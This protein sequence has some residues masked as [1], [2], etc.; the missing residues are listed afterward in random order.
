[1]E[2]N[3]IL[4][5]FLYE[6]EVRNYSI[7]TIKT[8]RNN[9]AL[10]HTYLSKEFNV[11]EVEEIKTIH[12]K[13]YFKYLIEKGLK[14]SYVNGILKNIRAYFRFCEEEEYIEKNPVSKVKWQKEGKTII[15][16]FNQEEI[17]NMLNAFKFKTYLEA[18]NKMMIAFLIDTGARNNELCTLLNEDVKERIIVLRGKGN[19][20]RHVSI[21]PLLKKYMIRYERIKVFYFKDRIIKINNYFLSNTGKAL[22]PE[23]VE[24]TV[25]KAGKIAG[26]RTEIRCSPHTIRHWYA[27]EQLKN[28]LDVYS[29]SGLLGHENITITKRYLQGIRD[30][31]IIDL[32]VKTS[33]LM[34]IKKTTK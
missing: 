26:V 5:E 11:L 15:N 33:P 16:T 12:I 18:R 28:G 30:E 22:T 10:F 14:P 3:D 17:I 31:D 20:Q 8:Y 9:N 23:T 2:L 25:K 27:Q 19:K 4:T 1:M 13:K 29:L 7:R 32:S 24:R 21:S 6:C 34:N